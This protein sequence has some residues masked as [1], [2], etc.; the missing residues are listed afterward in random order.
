MTSLQ[1]ILFLFASTVILLSTAANANA[2]VAFSKDKDDKDKDKDN[3]NDN[4]NENG[5]DNGST[6]TNDTAESMLQK[7]RIKT[8]VVPPKSLV[9]IWIL[10]AAELGFDLIT[11]GIAFFSSYYKIMAGGKTTECCGSNVSMGLLPMTTTIPFFFINCC[12]NYFLR[13]GYPFNIMAKY[14]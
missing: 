4:D 10:M 6:G 3:D 7:L 9:I 1:L 14:I 11:T 12:R 5:D 13:S 8:E 2:D